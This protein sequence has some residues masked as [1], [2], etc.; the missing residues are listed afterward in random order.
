MSGFCC[1][2]V[3]VVGLLVVGE[4][5]VFE[6]CCSGGFF[7]VVFLLLV[8]VGNEFL[9][10]VDVLVLGSGWGDLDVG[11]NVCWSLR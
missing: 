11:N 7:L 9:C 1:F 5:L 2:G 4:W 10:F 3:K 6:G 8:V